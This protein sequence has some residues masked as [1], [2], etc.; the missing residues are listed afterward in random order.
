M[1]QIYD[2]TI[3]AVSTAPGR[4][5][6]AIIRIS[7]DNAQKTAELFGLALPEARRA[8]LRYLRTGDRIIDRAIIVFFPG[9]AS[10]TGED[11][12]ELHVHG[13]KA[14]QEGILEILNSC[15]GFRPAE[16]GEFSRRAVV[17]NRLDLTAAEGINDLINA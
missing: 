13:G 12:I 15:E 14:I 1:K 7:G 16:A 3:Y 10:F 11:I 8:E 2:D 9:P 17:N 6:V 4:G 5:A